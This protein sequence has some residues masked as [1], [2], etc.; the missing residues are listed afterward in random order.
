MESAEVVI[1]GTGHG[2]ASAAIALRKHG[3]PGSITMVGKEPVAPYERPPLTK[4]YLTGSKDAERLLIR[5]AAYWAENNIDLRLSSEVVTVDPAAKSVALRNGEN[6]GYGKLIWAAG[7]QARRLTCD[8]SDLAGVH[9]VRDLADVDHLRSEVENKATR[10]VI[11]G[12]GYIGLEAAAALIELGADVVLL[13][14]LNRVLARVAGEPLS[15]YFEDLHRSHNV[16]IRLGVTIQC[17]E[18]SA[19]RA[20]GVRLTDGEVIEA[21]AVIVGIGIVPNTPVFAA[22]ALAMH[23]GVPVDAQCR[24][25]F[26]DIYAIGDCA[27]HHNRYAG[28]ERIRLE[29]VQNANDMAN[30]AAQSI[31]A[32]ELS[33]DAMP[34]FWSIQ[35][36][37][38]LQTVG[39]SRGSDQ[40]IVR[41]VPAQHAFSLVYL[42]DGVVIALD[43]VNKVKDY[44]QGRK[45]IEASSRP[46][47]DRLA[48]PTV[49]LSDCI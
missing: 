37:A 18:G 40:I 19:G 10:V 16:T 34:W 35:Y 31:L 17:I 48:D 46:D 32:A 27:A 33:Y 20:T 47:L 26:A 22:Q 2:G 7:G 29:S 49:N 5:P 45:L 4:E 25:E 13:E 23:N 15:R 28:G 21:D 30:V 11:I 42:K 12:G 36:G 14:T 41:G 3:F 8:G 39:L 43:C 44:V 38:R 6:I 9:T 24:T 1:V